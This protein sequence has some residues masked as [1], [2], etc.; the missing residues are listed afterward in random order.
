MNSMADTSCDFLTLLERSRDSQYFTEMRMGCKWFTKEVL[1]G[2]MGK[3]GET[4]YSREDARY[5]KL[6]PQSVPARCSG[7]QLYLNVCPNLR[8]GNWAFI[9]SITQSCLTL[10]PHRLQ[11]TRLPCPSPSPRVCSKSCPLS[12]WCHPTISSR[13][14]LFSCHQYFPASGSFPRN[15]FFTSGG[16]S[17]GVSASASYFWTFIL[18]H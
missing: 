13:F 15:Q 18:L 3:W 5:G 9:S 17:I 4:G 6:Q 2:D 8:Q 7:T 16:Q 11:H 1:P 10:Q 14:P 12:W